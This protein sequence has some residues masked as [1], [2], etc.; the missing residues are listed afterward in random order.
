MLQDAQALKIVNHSKVPMPIWVTETGW[1][2]TDCN[3]PAAPVTASNQVLY[4]QKMLDEARVSNALATSGRGGVT[5]LFLFSADKYSTNCGDNG[6]DISDH[7]IA[8][9]AGVMLPAYM[10]SHP[11]WP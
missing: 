3:Q 11:T 1:A 8:Q 7:G 5:H 9:L 2:L 4:E 10:Q 6:M